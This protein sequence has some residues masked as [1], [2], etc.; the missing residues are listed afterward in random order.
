M[1][2]L[3][4]LKARVLANKDAAAL[5]CLLAA[6]CILVVPLITLGFPENFDLPQHLRFARTFFGTISSGHIIP[7]WASADN[8]GFG[9]IGIRLYPPLTYIVMSCIQLVTQSWY[10]TLWLTIMVFMFASCA[11]MYFLA[12][13]W[14][15]Q[16]Y[17]VFAAIL[18]AIVPYHLIEIYQA[19]LL[20]EFA[21]AA[22]M[23]L[24]FLFAYRVV[25]RD[26]WSDALILSA[27]FSAIILA[28]IPAA[29]IAFLSLSIFVICLVK[30]NDVLRTATRLAVAGA[31]SLA[32]TCFYWL[33]LVT[34]LDWVKHN[35]QEF[36]ATGTYNYAD[37]FFP[38]YF[39]SGGSY[40]PRFLWLWDAII[41][42]TL[43]L[44]VPLIVFLIIRLMRRGSIP[45]HYYAIAGVGSLAFFMMSS[46][47]SFIW[48]SVS[49]LQKLQ[50]PWRWL[51]VA[52]LFGSLAFVAAVFE[53]LQRAKKP[54]R[55]PAYA[56]AMIVAAIVAV[57]STQ[58]IVP[59]TQVSRA[60]FDKKVSSL[61]DEQGCECW[62]PVWATEKA[63]E[64]RD[65]VAA[66]GRVV[67]ITRW[68][69]GGREFSIA[70]GHAGFARF[71]T[72][73][74]PYWAAEI[75]GT[76]QE[77]HADAD[78]TLIVP[79]SSAA[80]NISIRFRE[81][82]MYSTA[83]YLSLFSFIGILLALAATRSL[84]NRHDDP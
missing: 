53:F 24:C 62:W 20:A 68:D 2:I 59:S 82:V 12:K 60:E 38:L 55:V 36:Y 70:A 75:D 23:P 7:D 79:I 45:R 63:F 34:E 37:Y 39:N 72:F 66:E 58:L 16:S 71:A 67:S 1:A 14:L 3:G 21:A 46:L 10:D 17:A 48:N 33:R 42:L 77:A 54:G 74:Y 41:G 76:P 32:V 80:S 49:V 29:V 44:F 51:A 8:L 18:S 40:V 19:F 9:S 5:L 69:D 11:S 22:I 73:Y 50:F 6:S 13:E 56:L 83:R 4:P 27:C 35:S 78:G 31:S 61:D 43:L 28:H 30:R 15:P 65:R 47:S 26:R 64:R 52:S 25:V 84:P 57:D 81:P